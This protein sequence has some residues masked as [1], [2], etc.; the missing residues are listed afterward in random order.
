[1][2]DHIFDVKDSDIKVERYL[3]KEERAKV[4]EERK[5]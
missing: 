3:T 4:E 1:V 5:K 2:P